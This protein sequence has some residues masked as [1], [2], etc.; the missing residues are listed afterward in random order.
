MDYSSKK[1]LTHNASSIQNQT[2]KNTIQLVDNRPVSNIQQKLS[3]NN[4]SDTLQLKTDENES[5]FENE[6]THLESATENE[7]V[8]MQKSGSKVIQLG[9]AKNHSKTRIQD[10]D[11]KKKKK[12]RKFDVNPYKQFHDVKNTV[13]QRVRNAQKYI[14]KVEEQLDDDE[15]IRII[16]SYRN[17]LILLRRDARRIL[18]EI[19]TLPAPKRNLRSQTGDRDRL[20][21]ELNGCSLKAHVY[22]SELKRIFPMNAGGFGAKGRAHNLNTEVNPMNIPKGKSLNNHYFNNIT[23]DGKTSGVKVYKESAKAPNEKSG[24][25][26]IL[27]YS[28]DKNKVI[29]KNKLLISV[30]QNLSNIITPQ[31]VNFKNTPVGKDREG[32]QYK[33]MNNTNAA[34][35]AWLLDRLGGQRW[36]W[37]HIRGAGLGGATNSTNLVAGTRDANTHMIPFESNIRHL[38]TAV[39]THPNKYSRLQVTWSVSGYIARYAYSTIK[40]EWNLFRKNGTKQATGSVSFDPLD[41]SN[42]I[43]KN[44]VDKIENILSEIRNGL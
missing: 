10:L 14:A 36:E 23:L 25:L 24:P 9:K 18:N 17:K 19:I 3:G 2:T 38:G 6:E 33:N 8:Q 43:S 30:N 28:Y 16:E 41:T 32:G 21:S 1:Y 5:S 40:I 27:G 35:Y 12:D 26:Q 13:D 34:G 15:D 22:L 42:N 11:K 37:L 4:K 7:P 39:K 20:D 31:K 44:E 29:D